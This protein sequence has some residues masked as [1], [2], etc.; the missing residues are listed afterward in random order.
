[1]NV[2]LM[3]KWIWRLYHEED[4]IWA[5]L[6]RAK[7]PSPADMFGGNSS[8]GSPFWRSLHKIKHFFKLGVAHVVVDGRCTLFWLD[9]W[10]GTEPIKDRFQ[11]LFA[12][13]EDP[14]IS[15][16]QACGAPGAILFRCS[17]DPMLRAA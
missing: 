6:L 10:V 9:L 16:A 14:M 12:I 4:A 17:L 13:C 7:Y 8:D 3:L 11:S 2:A 15:V 1:M 5:K